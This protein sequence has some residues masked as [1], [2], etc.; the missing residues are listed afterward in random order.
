MAFLTKLVK[1]QRQEESRR[2]NGTDPMTM[3]QYLDAIKN[4]RD[5]WNEK[6]WAWFGYHMAAS[7]VHQIDIGLMHLRPD[8]ERQV[9]EDADVAYKKYSDTPGKRTT[10]DEPN[11]SLREC[12]LEQLKGTKYPW[13]AKGLAEKL[14]ADLKAVKMVLKYLK[15]D[16]DVVVRPSFDDDTGKVNG[17]GYFLNSNELRMAAKHRRRYKA[18]VENL[19]HPDKY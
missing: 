4:E 2:N 13:S 17:S 18:L 5:G 14:G 11:K 3:E 12:V 9:R 15:K 7:S 19:K 1:K 16:E 8:Q 6:D 10:S